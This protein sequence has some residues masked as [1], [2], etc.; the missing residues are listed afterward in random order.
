MRPRCVDWQGGPQAVSRRS[1]IN[2]CDWNL[3]VA[4][5]AR[6]KTC[7]NS[8]NYLCQNFPNF[9]KRP[10]QEERSRVADS[11]SDGDGCVPG[12]EWPCRLRAA[13][14]A[15]H[16]CPGRPLALRCSRGL[17]TDKMRIEAL[18][19]SSSSHR[20]ELPITT[21]FLTIRSHKRCPTM[22]PRLVRQRR[23]SSGM[24]AKMQARVSLP[25]EE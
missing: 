4:R 10:L 5:G 18:M 1:L 8:I 7:Q 16:Q 6:C 17:P 9:T 20:L 21:R 11:V 13:S 2:E 3:R 23:C 24:Q 22:A 25:Y 19:K 14:V 15:S 12:S